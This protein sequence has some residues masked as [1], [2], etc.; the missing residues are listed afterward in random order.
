MSLV[1]RVSVVVIVGQLVF[2]KTSFKFGPFSSSCLKFYTHR[3]FAPNLSIFSN[4][5]TVLYLWTISIRL[6]GSSYLF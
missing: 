2:R 3:N 6:V 4:F 1:N 5:V